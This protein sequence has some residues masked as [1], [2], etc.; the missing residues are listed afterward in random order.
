MVLEGDRSD[1]M[2]LQVEEHPSSGYLWQFGDLTEAGFTITGDDRASRGRRAY[3]WRGDADGDG[4]G[5]G[6]RGREG[7]RS[8]PG[9]PSLA[10][11][12]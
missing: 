6:W 2:V 12:S 5:R 7:S 8:P 4:G 11:R 1:L 3:R 9:D 10:A